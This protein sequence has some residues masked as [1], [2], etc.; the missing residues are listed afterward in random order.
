MSVA[1]EEKENIMK[2]YHLN[3]KKFTKAFIYHEPSSQ[4]SLK[5]YRL[6]LDNDLHVCYE[7]LFSRYYECIE[8]FRSYKFIV[9]LITLWMID[10]DLLYENKYKRGDIRKNLKRLLSILNKMEPTL[11]FDVERK[12]FEFLYGYIMREYL[13][14]ITGIV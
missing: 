1:N 14:T 6:T 10:L 7:S 9:P 13:F 4:K 2:L 3:P 5:F 11:S 12:Y 8:D